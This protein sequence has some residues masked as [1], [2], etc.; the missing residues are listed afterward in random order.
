MRTDGPSLHRKCLKVIKPRSVNHLWPTLQT[1]DDY[2]SG[3][4]LLLPTNIAKI[5]A[6]S[7]GMSVIEELHSPA[8]MELITTLPVL[9]TTN[10]FFT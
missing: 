9:C 1:H 5:P 7:A 6:C 10:L 3:I 8:C 4:I 2:V